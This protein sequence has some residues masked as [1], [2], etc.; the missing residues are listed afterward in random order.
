MLAYRAQFIKS[1]D[2]TTYG[3]VLI[4][5]PNIPAPDGGVID[6]WIQFAIATPEM[7]SPPNIKS[8]SM[9]AVHRS[10]GNPLSTTAFL[11]DF[12]RAPDLA[13][14]DIEITPTVSL[15]V[16]PS[17]NCYDC[18]KSGVIPIKPASTLVFEA[19]G[20]M[21]D[22][23]PDF[24]AI[25]ETIN[26]RIATYGKVN[27]GGMDTGAYGPSLGSSPDSLTAQTIRASAPDVP[28]APIAIARIRDAATCASCHA[29][30]GPLNY[31]QAVRS[32]F[33]VKL[34]RSH[35]GLVQTYVEKGWMPPGNTLT[36]DERHALWETVS[37][38]YFN[39]ATRT[40]LLVD[41]LRGG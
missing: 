24:D 19:G 31:L 25:D 22:R 12:M 30:F 8:V 38:Q 18:H 15:P 3:R 11:M 4:I 14:G 13:S 34:F 2:K 17:Q 27:L 9:V 7:A 29:Q 21:V 41:W 33:D 28:L 1:V 32:N 16:N 37:K 26:S 6:K 39:P 23:A 36:K 5:A 20:K 10:A 35:H 40:G